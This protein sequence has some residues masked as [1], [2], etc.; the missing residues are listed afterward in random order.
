MTFLT[1]GSSERAPLTA[2]AVA[3]GGAVLALGL[4][5]LID[6]Y[7]DDR[8]VYLLY[9]PLLLGVAGLGGRGPT[10]LATLLCAGVSAVF[11]RGEMFND[12]ANV[13]N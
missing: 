5:F 12:P 11:L 13:I 8:G 2:Y 10:V 7:F 3:V 9:V 4:C 1:A 6:P